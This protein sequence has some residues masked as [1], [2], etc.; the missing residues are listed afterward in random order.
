MNLVLDWYF[1]H[2]SLTLAQEPSWQ[3][4]DS[5][6][7][8]NGST[9]YHLL[10]SSFLYMFLRAASPGSWRSYVQPPSTGES[11][12]YSLRLSWKVLSNSV[13]LF[14]P[15]MVVLEVTVY[16]CPLRWLLRHL[17]WHMTTRVCWCLIIVSS[18][19]VT[20]GNQC[21]STPPKLALSMAVLQTLVTRGPTERV[22]SWMSRITLPMKLAK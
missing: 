7:G 9:C 18:N 15:W 8:F 16:I 1:Y 6:T 21:A 14:L 3:L 11:M 20:S 12:L 4:L 10:G 2:M 5:F 17:W 19:C 13:S 22:S